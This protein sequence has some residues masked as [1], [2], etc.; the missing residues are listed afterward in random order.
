MLRLLDN[1]FFYLCPVLGTIG[2]ASAKSGSTVRAA[3]L[4]ASL[5]MLESDGVV[6]QINVFYFDAQ[7]IEPVRATRC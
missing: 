1:R 6:N 4:Y 2:M 3:E 5:Q 7:S